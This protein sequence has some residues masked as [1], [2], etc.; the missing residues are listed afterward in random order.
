MAA[1]GYCTAE[2]V[3]NFLG[4]DFTAA[5]WAQCEKLIER[6]EAFI[7]NYT[8][9]GWLMGTQTDE[10]HY[11]INANRFIFLRYAPVSSVSA[12]TGTSSI[13]RG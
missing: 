5:Q 3:A 2:E 10:A 11:L 4:R 13:D 12:I 6:A 7:D 8:G 1:K 9:R